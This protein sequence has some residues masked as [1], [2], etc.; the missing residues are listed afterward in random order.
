MSE[1]K[2]PPSNLVWMDM[3]MTGLDPDKDAIIEMATI[4]TDWDLNVIAI[5]P[6]IVIHQ[7]QERFA[8][9][10][11]WN[12]EHHGKSG[13]WDR[14]V[15]SNIT[16][17]EAESQTLQFI[18]QYVG[19]KKSPLCGNSIWQDRR[20]LRR[21]M[22]SLDGYL[23][24]RIVDVSTVKELVKR[25]YYDPNEKKK[26][27]SSHRALDDIHESIAE[28]KTYRENFFIPKVNP[29]QKA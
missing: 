15:S 1:E 4:I 16:I 14:V 17:K 6:E 10:D 22:R 19:P 25:W 27:D 29:P 8:Q 24:Y 13:L 11:D 28:L 3:E 9:M 26:N 18:K 20:F 7:P 23:H 12:R 5:G 21:Y 2:G